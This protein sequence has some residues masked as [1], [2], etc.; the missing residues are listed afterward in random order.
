[1]AKETAEVFLWSRFGRNGR[2]IGDDLPTR[3]CNR[4]R[5]SGGSVTAQWS[6]S[7]VLVESRPQHREVDPV[8]FGEAH[9]IL[10][11]DR[12]EEHGR[13]FQFL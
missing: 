3:E 13:A 1:M 8:G 6:A 12:F 10:L 4:W 2:I 5:C 11:L 7:R 9:V